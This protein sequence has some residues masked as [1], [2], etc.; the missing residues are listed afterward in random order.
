VFSF[1]FFVL[2]LLL[3]LLLSSEHKNRGKEMEEK[4]PWTSQGEEI[5]S[6]DAEFSHAAEPPPPIAKPHLA[7]HLAFSLLLLLKR[8]KYHRFL[9][10]SSSPIGLPPLVIDSKG[11]RTAFPP[12]SS[13][14]KR[15]EEEEEEEEARKKARSLRIAESADPSGMDQIPSLIQDKSTLR[16]RNRSRA[17]SAPLEGRALKEESSASEVN[18]QV[19]DDG[20]LPYGRKSHVVSDLKD[21]DTNDGGTIDRLV[22]YSTTDPKGLWV[23]DIEDSSAG[24]SISLLSSVNRNPNP[25]HAPRRQYRSLVD[26]GIESQKSSMDEDEYRS[27]TT[28]DG[29]IKKDNIDEDEQQRDQLSRKHYVSQSDHEDIGSTIHGDVDRSGYRRNAYTPRRRYATEHNNKDWAE[30]NEYVAENSLSTD[31]SGERGLK[32]NEIFELEGFKDDEPIYSASQDDMSSSLLLWPVGLAVRTV[33]FQIRLIIQV[34]SLIGSIASWCTSFTSQ[35]VQET[36]DAKERAKEA[37]NQKV[38]MIAKVPPKVAENGSILLRRAGWGCL[39]ATY[40]CFLLC[41]LLLPALVLDYVFLNRVVEEPVSIREPL[42]FDYTLDHPEA[43]VSLC[44]LQG[45]LNQVPNNGKPPL[46][47]HREHFRAI[48]P[49]HKVHVTVIL[50]LPESD[51]NRN[52]G[53]FQVLQKFLPRLILFML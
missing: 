10:P 50:T 12:P 16:R 48:P 52:L 40:V 18:D 37:L 11:R 20:S 14:P 26:E 6:S 15:Q 45:S 28:E 22:G 3:L 31:G 9:L 23:E 42:H 1:F 27:L 2:L 29:E 17:A 38:S 21:S 5:Q 34:L 7:L 43:F 25:H 41:M 44:A 51:Y 35:R 4:K 53:M 30:Q 47:L 46:A 49:T 32:S 36:I 19:L 39:A 33:G 13:A 8:S 24:S